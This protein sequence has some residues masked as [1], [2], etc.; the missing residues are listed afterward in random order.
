[1]VEVG[2]VR[3]WGR[4]MQKKYLVGR[5]MFWR[6]YTISEYYDG[7]SSLLWWTAC[8]SEL[9]Y[10]VSTAPRDFKLIWSVEKWRYHRRPSPKHKWR[11]VQ[12]E[13]KPPSPTGFWVCY[14]PGMLFFI[15]PKHQFCKDCDSMT[16]WPWRSSRLSICSPA[17][18][19]YHGSTRCT[20]QRPNRWGQHSNYIICEAKLDCP[21]N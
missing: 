16:P 8:R 14:T 5:R 15:V 6:T 19:W 11:R 10:L 3:T 2:G 9:D 12:S 21:L 17:F 18:H 1:M 7:K 4:D 13:S 20:T